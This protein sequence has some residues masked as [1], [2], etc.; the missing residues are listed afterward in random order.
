MKKRNRVREKKRRTRK[1]T[2]IVVLCF[3]VLMA[4]G[5]LLSAVGV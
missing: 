3:G 2:S 1:W 5:M 4:L